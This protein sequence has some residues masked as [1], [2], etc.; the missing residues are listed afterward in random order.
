MQTRTNIWRRLVAAI[1][2][3]AGVG[4]VWGLGVGW[5][6]TL[7][8]MLFGNNQIREELSISLDGTPVISVMSYDTGGVNAL[9]RRTIDGKPWPSD[10]ELWLGGAHLERQNRPPGLMQLPIGWSRFGSR[11]GG[12]TDG[13]KPPTGWYIVSTDPLAERLYFAGFDPVSNLPVGYIGTAGF[14]LT[15]PPLEEQF[16]S[17]MDQTGQAANRVVGTQY[18]ERYGLI[19]HHSLSNYE[20]P[21]QWLMFLSDGKQLWEV[22]LRERTSRV[23]REI[24]D[25]ISVAMLSTLESTVTGKESRPGSPPAPARVNGTIQLFRGAATKNRAPVRL[26]AM[27]FDTFRASPTATAIFTPTGDGAEPPKMRQVVAVRTPTSLLLDDVID[28][29]ER[30]FKL[31][32]RIKPDTAFNVYW[33]NPETM[34]LSINAGYWSGG[35]VNELVWFTADGKVQREERVEL[36]GYVPPPERTQFWAFAAFMPEP[37][38][39]LGTVLAAVPLER[40]QRHKADTYAAA[41]SQAFELAWPMLII[42]CAVSVAA[43]GIAVHWQRRYFRSHTSV[44]AVFVF[45]FGIPGLFA[46]WLEHRGAKLDNCQECGHVVPRDRDACASCSTPFPTASHVETEIFA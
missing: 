36:N 38:G 3:A 15:A 42:V 17:P 1:V 26:V 41:L 31:P 23:L 5:I 29:V 8:T 30:E 6:L 19:R 35:P 14:R 20:R 28:N 44:W 18:V 43:A 7:G 46:Y 39:W 45:L 34:L 37:L 9:S 22:N 11:L 4:V 16:A 24:P 40:M 13:K 33:I 25:T 21:A 27:Q 2:V 12:L 10:Y 32:D